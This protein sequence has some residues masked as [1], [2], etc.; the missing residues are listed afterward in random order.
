MFR[1][2][3]KVENGRVLIRFDDGQFFEVRPWYAS[4]PDTGQL[5]DGETCIAHDGCT[6]TRR[7]DKLVV[8]APPQA[9]L[10]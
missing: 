3:V 1:P 10:S 4:D 8:T 6:W 2:A 5:K 9:S 7:G